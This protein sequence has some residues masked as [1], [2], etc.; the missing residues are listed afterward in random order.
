MR[1]LMVLDKPFPPDLRVENEVR[2]LR[3]AGHEV[4]VLSMAQGPNDAPV[5]EGVTVMR[6]EVPRAAS[7]AMRALAATLPALTVFGGAE[8]VR[9]A[10]RW[11]CDVVHVHDLYL[12]GA[13]VRAAR[14]LGT[15]LVV[16]LHEH[17]LAVLD[18]YRWS[19]GF[20][21]R[22]VVGRRRWHLAARRWLTRADAVVVVNE[23]MAADYAH[24]GV[25]RD[26]LLP[27][28]NLVDLSGYGRWTVDE[29][30]VA[31]LASRPTVL[32]VGGLVPNRGL[33]LAVRAMPEIA[34]RVPGAELVIVGDGS[35]RAPLEALARELDAPVRFP[36]WVAQ[37]AIPSWIDG[38]RVCIHP[39]RR[40]RQTE[41]ALSHKL[42]QYML[43]ARPVVVTDCVAMRRV[44]EG[45]AC[46]IVVPDGD[47]RAFAEAVAG[48]LLDPAA[49][50]R[51]GAAGRAAVFDRYHWDHGMKPLLA[52]Y[53][54]FDAKRARAGG[55]AR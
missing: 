17:W 37:E 13:G 18:D 3:A 40:T 6:R 54:A 27:V 25:P 49:A 8:I 22:Q 26:R 29:T 33:D 11:P 12:A 41:V 36:G 48:L 39:M 31:S 44:V 42:Y 52:W 4:A 35:E 19:S 28:P 10:R 23:D 7:N 43:A 50:A 15:G 21:R 9:A 55:A 30:L 2:S 20:P 51:Y 32:Y 38:A 34:A 24:C 5:P 1:I 14:A 53:G 47:A 16:D 45:A 46:G